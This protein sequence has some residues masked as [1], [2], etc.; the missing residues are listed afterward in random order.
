[1]R[2]RATSAAP[3]NR[4]F[5]MG[6]SFLFLFLFVFRVSSDFLPVWTRRPAA[7]LHAGRDRW[8]GSDPAA[9]PEP[10]EHA[11]RDAGAEDPEDRIAPFRSQLRHEMEVHAVDTREERQRDEDRA[12]HREGLHD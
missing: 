2:A 7:G 6:R 5:F 10:G 11:A 3:R 4:T 8:A 9:V 12:D 1:M